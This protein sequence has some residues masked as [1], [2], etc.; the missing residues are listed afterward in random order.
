MENELFNIA[1]ISKHTL[2]EKFQVN[3]LDILPAS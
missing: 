3:H 1:K 2:F